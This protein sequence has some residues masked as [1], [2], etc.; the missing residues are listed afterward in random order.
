MILGGFGHTD[1]GSLHGLTFG[2]DGRLYFTMGEPDGWKLP[3]GDGTLLE[4]VAGAIFRSRVD[5]S[6]PEVL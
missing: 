1:N 5:G 3:R 4:G 6:R 2:P